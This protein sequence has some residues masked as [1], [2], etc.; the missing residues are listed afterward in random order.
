ML[1]EAT[2]SF[3][4]RRFLKR[5]IEAETA[6]E[7]E[8]IA[9]AE[10]R[11]R[12]NE[13]IAAI[14]NGSGWGDTEPLH[15]HLFLDDATGEELCDEPLPDPDAAG[16][17]SLDDVIAAGDNL[18]GLLEGAVAAHIYDDEDEVPDD[19]HYKLALEEW[20]RAR[21]TAPCIRLGSKIEFV[22]I[23]TDD[24]DEAGAPEF[25]NYYRCPD[26]DN[27]WSDIWTATCDDDCPKCGHRHVSPYESE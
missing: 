7:A 6:E 3:N 9:K 13:E 16:D 17:S 10:A 23:T 20:G 12:I 5:E 21:L 8:R 4:V 18:A 15:P 14:Q 26:C 27:E 1:F 2:Y 25:E 11:D 22:D 19:D 24:E